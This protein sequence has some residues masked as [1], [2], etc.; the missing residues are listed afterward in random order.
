M[1]GVR[2][3]LALSDPQCP[4]AEEADHE[5]TAVTDVTRSNPREGQV[6]EE[7]TVRD[8]ETL[9]IGKPV[10]HNGEGEIRQF[11]RAES[12]DCVCEHIEDRG[13]PIADVS[14]ADG[15]IRVSFH[16]EDTERVTPLLESLREAYGSTTLVR[17]KREGDE[18]DVRPVDIAA[19]TDRQREVLRT[20][21]SMG[22]FQHPRGAHAT[23]VA[24]ALDISVST[25][26]EHLRAAEAKVVDSLV[27]QG[28]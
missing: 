25:F 26:S 21:H 9:S 18:A 4:V 15:T 12:L 23:D 27:A 2:V 22:Y 7:L 19:L 20:A 10:F 3:T 17:A 8:A 24:E 14:I 6:T 16:V 11:E 1:S 28:V 5:G 13:I